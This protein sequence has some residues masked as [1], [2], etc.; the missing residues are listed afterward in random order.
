MILQP[1]NLEE[2]V[3]TITKL[4]K[5]NKRVIILVNRQTN[6]RTYHISRF[7]IAKWAKEEALV[8]KIPNIY[9]PKGLAIAL[10]DQKMNEKQFREHLRGIPSDMDIIDAFWKNNI[11]SPVINFHAGE[12]NIEPYLMFYLSPNS[13]HQHLADHKFFGEIEKPGEVHPNEV[14][15]EYFVLGKR[16]KRNREMVES[17]GKFKSLMKGRN[18]LFPSYFGKDKRTSAKDIAYFRANLSADMLD[19]I[20]KLAKGKKLSGNKIDEKISR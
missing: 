18:E 12:T 10:R 4:P 17:F 13:R 19:I 5:Q 6:E 16:Q 3:K 15:V 11:R 14:L 2:M 8:V 9:T 7:E 1:K 20:K